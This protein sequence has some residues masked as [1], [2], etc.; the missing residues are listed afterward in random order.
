LSKR[1]GKKLELELFEQTGRLKL[2]L[3]ETK[4]REVEVG[5]GWMNEEG[6]GCGSWVSIWGGN[7]RWELSEQRKREL[8]VGAGRMNEWGGSWMGEFGK[9][10]KEGVGAGSW[11]NEQTRIQPPAPGLDVVF[12]QMK[13]EKSSETHDNQQG[14][15]HSHLPLHIRMLQKNPENGYQIFF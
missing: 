3:K 13:L 11:A 2:D 9:R 4:R 5:A 14:F 12:D 7:W 6:V 15:Y 10:M 1:V 8:D